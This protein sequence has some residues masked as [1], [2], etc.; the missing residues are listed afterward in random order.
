MRG[1]EY[2]NSNA[3]PLSNVK[4]DAKPLSIIF[5]LLHLNLHGISENSDNS[6]DTLTTLLQ[7]LSLSQLLSH[8]SIR[9]RRQILMEVSMLSGRSI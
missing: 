3:E 9:P 4:M 2:A 8:R 1:C 5:A 7:Q 6:D